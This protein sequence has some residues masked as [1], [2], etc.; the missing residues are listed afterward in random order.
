[1]AMFPGK[2]Q[3]NKLIRLLP[4]ENKLKVSEPV[5]LLRIIW[6]MKHL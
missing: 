5:P 1:M 3:N 4:G 2:L 6:L